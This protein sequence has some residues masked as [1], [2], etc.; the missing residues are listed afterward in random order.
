MPQRTCLRTQIECAW[1]RTIENY[2]NAQ[3]INSER[4]LQ[5]YFCAELLGELKEASGP[6]R[7]FIEP[8]IHTAGS[9]KPKYPDIV[10][11][12]TKSVIGI[13]EIKY[14]P[15]GKPIY[16]KDIDTLEKLLN[17]HDSVEIANTRYRGIDAGG[18]FYALAN[19]AVF[20]W[21]GVYAGKQPSFEDEIC[22]GLR[23]RF[24]S[25]HAIT[26]HGEKPEVLV[27]R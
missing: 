10:I 25:L 21:A 24:M 13:I 5:V 16:Q 19:D 11:C 4:G 14:L 1:R 6:R 2:Y 17:S 3:L 20:C 27:I 23:K 26:Q 18:R 12:N 15:R 9:D 22:N 8:S 7:I